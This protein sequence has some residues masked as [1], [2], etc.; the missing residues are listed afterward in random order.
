[1]RRLEGGK[2]LRPLGEIGFGFFRSFPPCV[3]QFT[4]SREEVPQVASVSGEVDAHVRNR[5]IRLQI[6]RT[7][8]A[9]AAL[10]LIRLDQI[11]LLVIEPRLDEPECSFKACRYI[12][13]G[14]LLQP[15]DRLG[16]LLL[17]LGSGGVYRMIKSIVRVIESVLYLRPRVGGDRR[18]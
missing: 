6:V 7:D 4:L 2:V 3:I 11:Q 17:G 18:R 5:P 12:S 8:H 10:C 13:G 1:M 9:R 16:V 14:L 15:L